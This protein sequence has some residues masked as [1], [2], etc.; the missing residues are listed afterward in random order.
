MREIR[1]HGRF[2]QPFGKLAT[3]IGKYAMAQGKHAQVFN[4][5]AAFRPGGPTYAVVRTDADPIRIRSS[6]NVTPDIVVILDNSLFAATDVTK[7]LKP[8]GIVMAT[9]VDQ[10]VLGDKAKDFS[11]VALDSYLKD[12]APGEIEAG[13]IA[14]LESQ[15][16]F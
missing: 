11:F 16:A 1:L 8:G 12:R 13:L 6:N 7:G 3:A 15:H 5:F 14:C 4:A 9:G 10:T 2:G